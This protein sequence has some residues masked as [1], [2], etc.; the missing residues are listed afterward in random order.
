VFVR[1]GKAGHKIG[2]KPCARERGA[3]QGAEIGFILNDKQPHGVISLT[4]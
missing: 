2:G 3:Q 1:R 4:A